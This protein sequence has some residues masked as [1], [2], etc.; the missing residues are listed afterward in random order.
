M[1]PEQIQG[2]KIT[3]AIALVVGIPALLMAILLLVSP[4]PST[5][6]GW[7]QVILPVVLAVLLYKGYG[8]ARAYGIFSLGL[9]SVWLIL[10][11]LL[12]GNI[13]AI[14]ITTPI[15]AINLAAAI[16]LWKSKSVE[17]YF[18][19]QTGLR[20]GVPSITSTSQD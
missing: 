5:G 12:S 2:R 20:E 9:G 19:R 6:L 13:A 8:R 18:D 7:V 1:T 10:G 3:I 15:Y 16:V 11:T 17:A 4:V 14:V